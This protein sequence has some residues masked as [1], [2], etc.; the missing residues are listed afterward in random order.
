[1]IAG[2]T[3]RRKRLHVAGDPAALA[4]IVDAWPRTR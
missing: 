3:A 4:R 2:M 1:M